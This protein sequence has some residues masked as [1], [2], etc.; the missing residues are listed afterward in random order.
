M[1][2]YEQLIIDEINKGIDEANKES[3][4][5]LFGHIYEIEINKESDE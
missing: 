1:S 3:D 2:E 5:V 4:Q